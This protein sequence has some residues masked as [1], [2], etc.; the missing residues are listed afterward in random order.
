VPAPTLSNVA[1]TNPS[2]QDVQVSFDSDTQ[3]ST[4]SVSISGAETAPLTEADFTESGS[5]GSYT[6]TATYAGSSD[7]T[8]TATVDTAKDS[9][10][11]DGANGESDS[12]TIDTTAPTI[13]SY[14][15]SNPSGQDVQVSFD[16]DEQLSSISVSI[17]GAETA[18]LTEGDFTETDN[19][20]SYTY[21]A[22]YAGSS[23]DTYTATVDT[24]KDSEGNDGADGQ[25]DSVS[26]DTTPPA[27]PST[28]DLDASSDSGS[29]NTDNVTSDTTPTLSGTAEASSTVEVFSDTDGS[30]G[31]TNA[32]G[33][34]DWTFTP[35]SA[36]SEG[37]HS[38]TATATDAAGNTGA[39]SS[40]LSVTVDTTAPSAPSAPDLDAASDT[41]SS[42]TDDVTSDTTPTFS[43][44]VEADATVEL[45]SDV[46]SSLGTTT[47]DGT[48]DWTITPGSAISATAHSITVT[49]TDAAGN[50]GAASSAL[51]VTVDTT[52]PTADAGSE[53]T[54]TRG[55]TTTLDATDSSDDVGVAAYDWTFG[56]GSTAT[57]ATP[58]HTYT[59]T[60]TDTAT[61][62]VTDVA[63]NIDTDTVTVTVLARPNFSVTVAG[64]DSPV[65]ASSTL[66]VEA[67]VENVGDVAGTQ[68]VTLDVG[69]VQRDA[70][71]LS[72]AGGES[73]T[74]TFVWETG[75]ADRGAYTATVTSANDSATVA[76]DVEIP[77]N[78][79]VD[80][81]EITSPVVEGERLTVTATVRN[82]GD[83]VATKQVAL[84]IG[85]SGRS[86]RTLT[87][88][89][90]EQRTVTLG[91]RTHSGDTGT[92]QAQVRSP[93]T[94]E[95][96]SVAVQ[97][98]ASL[99]VDD[100]TTTSPVAAGDT[101]S[102]TATV[103]N[104]GGAS[105]TQI[106]A[107][108]LDGTQQ[109]TT[110][111]TLSGSESETLAFDWATDAAD[112]G[113]HTVAVSL[114]NGTQSAS[115]TVTDETAP[116]VRDFAATN[117]EGRTVKLTLDSDE[118][119]AAI[120]VDLDGP[121]SRTLSRGDF[122]ET[123]SEGN[124]SYTAT[125]AVDN[126]TYTATLRTAADA[127]GNDGAADQQ[128]TIRVGTVV[129]VE[130]RSTGDDE[131]NPGVDVG[132]TGTGPGTLL[133]IDTST[134]TTQSRSATLDAIGLRSADQPKFTLS[135]RH[136]ETNPSETV[137]DDT[138]GSRTLQ[139]IELNH[140][141]ADEDVSETTL[142]VRV[143]RDRVDPLANPAEQISVS[144]YADGWQVLEKTLVE[145]TDD[146]YVFA[147][148]TP[149]FSL[150]SVSVIEPAF[151][152]DLGSSASAL[153]AGEPA[154]ITATVEN[155]GD[156][157]G[158]YDVA[159]RRDG[160]TVA[161]ETVTVEAGASETVSIDQSFDEPGSYT[162]EVGE[163][164]VTVEVAAATTPDPTTTA[165]DQ[166]AGD[167]SSGSPILIV[168]VAVLAVVI[169]AVALRFRADGQVKGSDEQDETD[170]TDESESED[171]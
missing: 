46:G 166:A 5:A 68:T 160:A 168:V 49:A 97:T 65:L 76:V 51:S 62:T 10:G 167:D 37:T 132:V 79:E 148:E 121:P 33:N 157:R 118:A 42:S 104:D 14:A 18:T 111:V 45:V 4:I 21:S 47:A 94:S 53:Q 161:T 105:A 13:S 64:A 66:T 70:R 38:I 43:G 101:L 29:S 58:T 6:Y 158:S 112:V 153:P 87:L 89:P 124:Y 35:G 139:Y 8:Y 102:I 41:G 163:E 24:A 17:S 152:V 11:N 149:G 34:G 81:V 100:L 145:T 40:A 170:E 169:A 57:G 88:A 27:A 74:A 128:A 12:V 164:S 99:V 31:T 138:G 98:P 78:F 50:T 151:E 96:T 162:L 122:T 61:L 134:P 73:T 107:L 52:A 23:D 123:E 110:E 91:W 60:G 55:E 2:G 22:T 165:P 92:Y 133:S 171:A 32:D 54:L 117:P 26:I 155:V 56:D 126:G 83:R 120:A 72:L 28:P 86:S 82:R 71:T 44:T 103:R 1:A 7:G 135:I 84:D 127:A 159:F 141:F 16:S 59:T 63:G 116:T 154:T 85:S 93:D 15:V 147:V 114:A 146:H 39:A 131:S 80:I 150:F 75:T 19:D 140:S 95:S 25:S 67:T 36:I 144:R 137:S 106:V 48:G 125:T 109:D 9:E 156:Y 119:L 129:A 69:G 108:L 136:Y 20:G 130:D 142:T 143:R 77:G 115:V 3:L 113:T 90:G 30:L